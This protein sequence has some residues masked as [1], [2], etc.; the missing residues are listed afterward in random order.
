M[1]LKATMAENIREHTLIVTSIG[2]FQSNSPRHIQD[3]HT[4]TCLEDWNKASLLRQESP[5]LT[6][7]LGVLMRLMLSS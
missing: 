3:L 5:R 7:Y 6:I 1:R 4:V 2:S